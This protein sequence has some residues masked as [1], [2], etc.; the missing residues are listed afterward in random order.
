MDSIKSFLIGLIL[1]VAWAVLNPLG[2]TI[3]T[4]FMINLGFIIGIIF[5]G[6]GFSTKRM[7][8]DFR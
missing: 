4:R 3:T 5:I 8:F 7:R 2:L 1:L 6:L